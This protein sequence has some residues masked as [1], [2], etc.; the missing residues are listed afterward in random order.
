MGDPKEIT[1]Y[2]TQSFKQPRTKYTDNFTPGNRSCTFLSKL[3][4]S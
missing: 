1:L 3:A 4:N 2:K